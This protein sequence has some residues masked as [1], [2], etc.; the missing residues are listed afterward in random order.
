MVEGG[1]GFSFY[2]MC[3]KARAFTYSNPGL[4]RSPKAMGGNL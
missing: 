1:K 2:T 3:R 4:G